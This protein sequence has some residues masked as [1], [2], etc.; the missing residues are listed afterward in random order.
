[1]KKRA[2]CLFLCALCLVPGA[3][4][5]NVEDSLIVGMVSTR[6]TEIR[7]FTPQERDI[8]S[9][10]A[11]VYETLVTIDDNGLPQPNLAESWNMSEGG[12]TW[13]F[14]LRENVTFSD[15]TP[16]TA[17]DVAASLNYILTLAASENSAD[18]GFF[19]NMRY[20]VKSVTAKDER[21]VEVQ[22][23]RD[24]YGLLYA[25]T[26]PVVPASQVDAASPLG[27]GPYQVREFVAGSHFWL[28]VNPNW[29]QTQPQVKEI[30]ATFYTNNRDLMTAYEYG[31]VDTAFTRSM[32]AAQYRSGQNSL[33]ITY[34]TRQLETLMINHANFPLD[35]LKVRQAIRYAINEALIVQNVYM[36][37]ALDADTP[38]PSDSW[39]YY[40]QESAYTYDPDRARQLLAE[41]G[42]GD[43]NDDG[44]LDILDGDRRRNMYLSLYVYEDP[45]YDVRFATAELIAD[46][47][48]EVGIQVHIEAVDFATCK[49]KLEAGSYDLA[50]CAFQMDVVPD[51]GFFLYSGNSQNYSRYRS[52]VMDELIL[53]LRDQEA[54]ADF[55]YTS[56]EIQ[57]QFEADTPFLCLFYRTGTVLTRRMYTTARAVREFEL[58]RG[59]ESFGRQEAGS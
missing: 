6:T 3:L 53:T 21:T 9:M 24:Y 51:V 49:E 13:T 35:R 25:M 59:I 11:L 54:Q 17:N 45:E 23:A 8:L 56:Q 20:L 12:A 29:W 33:S 5:S 39:L 57:R 50:L 28:E 47:L 58:L 40:D 16:L 27:T 7:P 41:D 34:S 14:A 15:G 1:M 37:M 44:T 22:A 52:D 10:Y 48:M 19:A 31:R 26:F 38:Y 43:Y 46:M 4:A 36:G 42:W 18:R 32:A 55:Y 30:M 2:L